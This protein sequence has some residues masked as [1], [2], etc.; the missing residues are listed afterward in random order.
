MV[1]SSDRKW[2]ISGSS[3]YML[4]DPV[5][6]WLIS[7]QNELLLRVDEQVWL[8]YFIAY[9]SYIPFQGI[10]PEISEIVLWDVALF[11]K[12]KKST[13]WARF[14]ATIGFIQKTLCKFYILIPPW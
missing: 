6:K 11:K 5:A 12:K 14:L 13:L 4:Q 3:T 2:L 1:S 9:A 7:G 8:W 10:P